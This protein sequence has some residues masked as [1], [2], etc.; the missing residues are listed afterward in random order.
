MSKPDES[1]STETTE[2]SAP[3]T[4]AEKPADKPDAPEAEVDERDNELPEWARKKLTKANAESANYRTRLREAEA[5]LAEAKT[6]QEMEAAIAA[7]KDT[8]AKLER[9]ILVRDVADEVGL[10]KELAARL[11]GDTREELVADAKNLAK[12]A[13]TEEREP[14]ELSGG[15]DPSDREGAFDPVKAAREAM[16]R[17]Y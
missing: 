16:T 5:K 8:N 15:L 6:P 13:P 12:F 14:D 1:T 3:E 2:Q 17:R 4:P 11:V 7:F 10:P 9:Q